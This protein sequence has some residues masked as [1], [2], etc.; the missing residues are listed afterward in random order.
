MTIISIILFLIQ[1]IQINSFYFIY[2]YFLS[3]ANLDRW[4]KFGQ[5]IFFKKC[6]GLNFSYQHECTSNIF[7]VILIIYMTFL[8]CTCKQ[9]GQ[10][11]DRH[12]GIPF[13]YEIYFQKTKNHNEAQETS[14]LNIININTLQNDQSIFLYLNCPIFAPPV[15]DLPLSRFAPQH[16]ISNV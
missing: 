10:I 8:E 14:S 1:L 9:V 6:I 16:C 13:C 5:Q 15:P 12:F 4:G 2:H 7:F 11:L 3:G